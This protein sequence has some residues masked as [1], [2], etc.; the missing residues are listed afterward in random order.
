MDRLRQHWP[1]YLIEG[2]ALGMFMISAG[3][4]TT[5]FEAPGWLLRE[6]IVDADLRRVLIGL[7][8]GLTAIALIYS[9]WG[10][11]SG[12]HMNPAVTFTFWRLG[13]VHGADAL[14]YVAAQFV[15]GTIG[16]L[17]VVALLGDAFTAAPVRFV[18]TL[19]GP[20]GHAVAFL[21]EFVISLLLMLAVLTVSN[22]P[23]CA[24]L[25]GLVAGAL[26]AAWIGIEAPLS[27]MSMNPA[28]SF[29]S[30][31][32]GGIWEAL[33]LYFTAPVLGMLA[34]AGLWRL[35]D[36]RVGCAKLQ[37]PLDVRCIHCGH[38]PA[39]RNTA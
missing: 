29:A 15:G 1:E 14:A 2:W 38:E 32:P 7:C 18:V 27:G 5:L 20:S 39:T 6:A 31:A 25:T 12:A 17:V 28:R 19:P 34:A 35:A 26:V 13:K 9:P 24:R 3:V 11:R 21:A 33:W 30:A 23:R 22:H 10:Q 37:H 4:V 36:R 16:V 8:M